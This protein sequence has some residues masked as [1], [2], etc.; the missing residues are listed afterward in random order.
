VASFLLRLRFPFHLFGAATRHIHARS[1]TAERP[2]TR[3]AHR[4]METLRFSS[5][6]SLRTPFHIPGGR[7]SFLTGGCYS[8]PNSSFLPSFFIPFHSIHLFTNPAQ[9]VR[10]WRGGNGQGSQPYKKKIR[11]ST[12]S[13]NTQASRLPLLLLLSK[14]GTRH[15][16]AFRDGG[17][18]GRRGKRGC[19]Y[20]FCKLH[21]YE[22]IV[23]NRVG[24]STRAR[25]YVC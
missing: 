8:L 9:S 2:G 24:S 15:E 4:H 20:T 17:T 25:G 3:P 10:T 13:R 22:G 5:T 12:G 7:S 6:Q 11:E 1:L 23:S 19:T 14:A 16:R 18:A 21:C